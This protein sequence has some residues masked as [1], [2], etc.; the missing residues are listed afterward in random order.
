MSENS[1][2]SESFLIVAIGASAGG[3]N[4]LEC[5]V[6]KLPR[7]FGFPVSPVSLQYLP[8]PIEH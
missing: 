5:F 7:G 4:A 1:G 6:G 3:L 8:F 2:R